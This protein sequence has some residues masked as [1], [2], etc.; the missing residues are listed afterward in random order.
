[1]AIPGIPSG[2][3]LQQGNGQTF[4]SWNITAGAANY[5]VNRSTDGVT[6]ALLASPVT[7]YYLDSA[8]TVGTKYYY[9]IASENG[10]GVSSF[11]SYQSIVPTLTADLSLG[12]LRL[13]AQQ[14]ADLVGSGF[15]TMPEWNTYINQSA[16]E[17][18]DLL[19]TL[20]EDY[21]LAAPYTFTTDGINAQYTMPTDFYKLMGV[22]VG[23]A[24]G[25]NAFITLKKFDFIQRN[26][27]VYPNITSTFLGVFN[28]AYRLLGNSIMFIPTPASGQ[29]VKVWY[30]PKMVQLLQDTDIIKG[31]SGWTEYVIVD[32][33]I[34]A[35]QKEESDVTVLQAQ[36][37][38][39]IKR[40]EDSAMNRDVGQPDRISDTRGMIGY[41][42]GLGWDGSSGGV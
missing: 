1:M 42:S 35:L 8:V 12:Q 6:F 31:I 13:L 26:R 9:Q 38:A 28:L 18:Y 24:N 2:F 32:A 16:F 17:L 29:F 33:A 11:T 4:L 14:R 19:V 30:I 10:D 40:I 34:K 20:Y 3:A 22:D 36:K 23:L 15:V 27:Y 21:H 37:M 39:L 25:Q 5:R 7:N 41:G